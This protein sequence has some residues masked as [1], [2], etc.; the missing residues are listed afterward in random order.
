M[1]ERTNDVLLQSDEQNV[2]HSDVAKVLYIAKPVRQMVLPAVMCLLVEL[3]ETSLSV[4][5]YGAIR[6]LSL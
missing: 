6:M 2:F 3:I 5:Y 1:D 4:G